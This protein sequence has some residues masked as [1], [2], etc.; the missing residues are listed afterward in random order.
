MAVSY[1][2][3]LQS[4]RSSVGGWEIHAVHAHPADGRSRTPIV[5]V[6]GWGVAGQYLVPLA[7]KLARAFPVYVP[8]LPGHGLSSQPH[9]AL[10]LGE[11]ANALALWM[12]AQNIGRALLVGQ[13]LGCQIV[14]ELAARRPERAAGLVLI[15][16]T[17][18]ARARTLPRQIVRLVLAG[19]W[20]RAALVPIV[21][22]DYRRMGLRRLRGEL[23]EMFADAPERR[24][25]RLR[26]PALVIRGARDAVVPPRWA[27]R[28]A[29]LLGGARVV[30]IPGGAHAIQFS[31]PGEVA[32]AI[33]RFAR[34]LPAARSAPARPTR[35]SVIRP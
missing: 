34:E 23:R 33:R 19:L 4:T 14:S 17:V 27:R 28:V 30:T 12:A 5:L 9:D 21:V 13:S 8:D 29:E 3:P 15:G 25:P 1:P 10:T 6:H 2:A 35:R 22:Q 31:A 16:P 7:R 32:A 11:L 18:D 26:I 20:E 24:L